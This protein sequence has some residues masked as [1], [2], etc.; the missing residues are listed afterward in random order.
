MKFLKTINAEIAKKLSLFLKKDLS[1]SKTYHT[2]Y[3]A[4]VESEKPLADAKDMTLSRLLLAEQRRES[5]RMIICLTDIDLS[6]PSTLEILKYV[7][8]KVNGRKKLTFADWKLDLDSELNPDE[9]IDDAMTSSSEWSRATRTRILS[10][11]TI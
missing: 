2:T 5:E 4:Q 11:F 10:K 9:N 1:A 3:L 6:A 7:A 8:S